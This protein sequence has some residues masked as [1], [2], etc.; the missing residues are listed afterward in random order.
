LTALERKRLAEFRHF[1]GEWLPPPPKRVLEVGCGDGSLALELARDGYDV[2]AIDPEAPEGSI[3]RRVSLE[4][5]R[6]ERRFDAVIA[7]VS[8]HHVQDL[9]A[10]LDRISA[11]LRPGRLLV[12]EEFAKER[13]TGPTAR[14]YF[15][16]RHAV[17][18]VTESEA[19]LPAAFEDWHRA[20][21]EQH[22]NIHPLTEVR[23]QL[24]QRFVERHFEWVPYLYD[25]RLDD[26][27]EPLERALIDR[28]A[29][30]ATG[31]RYVA[32]RRR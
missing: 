24:E 3:F 21:G 5:L 27:L 15:H 11:L 31:C 19:D 32:E 10:A 20:W 7:S 18:A 22:A 4:E 25:Y 2:V 23:E 26:A 29:I 30:D 28:G 13:L 8:L 16:Q 12:L 14:W 6:D 1:L 9:G 17:A